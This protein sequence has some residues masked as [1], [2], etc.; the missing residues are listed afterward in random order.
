MAASKTLASFLIFFYLQCLL[1]PNNY[2]NPLDKTAVVRLADLKANGFSFCAFYNRVIIRP[3]SS[4]HNGF[5][6]TNSFPKVKTT[7]RGNTSLKIP[8]KDP[9]FNLTIFMDVE[10]NPGPILEN[11]TFQLQNN[12]SFCTRS[13]LH[14]NYSREE[15]KAL[16]HFSTSSLTSPLIHRLKELN[17]LRYRG[18][19][20]GTSQLKKQHDQRK[21]HAIPVITNTRTICSRR[22]RLNLCSNNIVIDCSDSIETRINKQKIA[23]AKVPTL[24]VANTQSLVP[25]IDEVGSRLG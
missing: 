18:T 23:S 24:M 17:I 7:K 8:G 20:A 10:R 21:Y 9:D 15:L 3:A 14:Y 25:K 5:A 12:S 11:P 2:N 4:R 13:T 1:Q 6:R 22:T 16:N 19:R